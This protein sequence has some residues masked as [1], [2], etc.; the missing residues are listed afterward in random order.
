MQF[1]KELDAIGSFAK[2]SSRSRFIRHGLGVRFYMQRGA[3]TLGFWAVSD[4]LNG[5][6]RLPAYS[7]LL[8]VVV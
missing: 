8:Q 7:L 4:C 2:Q 1:Y 5:A 3:C 6:L